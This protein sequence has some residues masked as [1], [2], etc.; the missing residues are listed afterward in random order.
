MS[1][2]AST[3]RVPKYCKQRDKSRGDRAYVRIDG[4][5]IPL[6]K[7]GSPESREK[8]AELI[9]KPLAEKFQ[10]KGRLTV[11]MLMAE[12]LIHAKEYYPQTQ[13]RRVTEFDAIRCALRHVRQVAGS[14]PA[15]EFG[16]KKLKAVR[17][18]FIEAGQCRGTVNQNSKRVVRMF[19]W[20]VSEELIPGAVWQDLAAVGGL[21]RGK[22]AAK[23]RPPV[24]PVHDNTVDATLPFM[25]EVVADMVRLQRATAMRPAEVCMIRPC[26]I[27]RTGEV[28]LYRPESHKTEYCGKERQV[29]IGPRGQEILLNYLIRDSQNY[30]FRPCDSE[31]KR[32]ASQHEYRTTPITYGNRPGTNRVDNPKRSAGE[33]YDTNAY[34]RAIHRACDKAFPVPEGMEGEEVKAWKSAHRWSPNQLRHSAATEIRKQFGLEA[35]QVILGHSAAD[36]TQVYAERD[37]AKGLEVAMR[38]G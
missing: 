35:T 2:S 14:L 25:P 19:R 36:I 6:G 37:L 23:D 24:L 13:Q 38:I 17:Q 15:I 9:G 5:K 7:Y 11:S 4:K 20:A 22:T 34:R 18:S 33:K 32:R 30:C 26:D 27:D 28:W 29:L 1:D 16:P 3:H 21:R 10:A 12:Y 8:Y 31:V